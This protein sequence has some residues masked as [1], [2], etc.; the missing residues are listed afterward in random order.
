VAL[1]TDGVAKRVCL[2]KLR[3]RDVLADQGIVNS[4]PVEIQTQKSWLYPVDSPS[5]RKLFNS[6]FRTGPAQG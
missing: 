4:L 1:T 3:V 2:R 6:V 5:L